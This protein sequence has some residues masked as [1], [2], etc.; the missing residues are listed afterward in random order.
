M[1]LCYGKIVPAHVEALGFVQLGNEG[2]AYVV[3]GGEPLARLLAQSFEELDP[4][5]VAHGLV[6]E[7][8]AS[9]ARRAYADPT[10]LFRGQL[11]QSVWARK[12][13]GD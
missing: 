11:M 1:D 13:G 6:T 5:L 4:Q 3:H 12:P 7:S 10:F 8:Q 2:V 9:G